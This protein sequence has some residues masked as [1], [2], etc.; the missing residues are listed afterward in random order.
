MITF[1]YAQDKNGGIGLNNQLPWHLPGDLHFFKKTTMGK[2]I[3]MG[4][5]TF[6]SMGC[7]LL[8]GRKSVVLTRDKS[9]G[10]QIEGLTVLYSKNEVL[11]LA[12]NEEVMIIGGA[13]I[14]NLFWNE[15]NLIIRTYIDATFECDVFM[16]EINKVDWNLLCSET[17]VTDQEPIINYQFQKWERIQ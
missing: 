12:K 17:H 2:T 14:F 3:V 4:R 5:K 9:Y 7:R 16:P 8:P 6:E 13:E 11:N 10:H 15:A 1:V